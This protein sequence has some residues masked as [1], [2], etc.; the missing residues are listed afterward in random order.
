M[1]LLMSG[2]TLALQMNSKA[3]YHW[4]QYEAL[5]MNSK[6]LYHT[7]TVVRNLVDL[8]AE[9]LQRDRVALRTTHRHLDRHC[10]RRQFERVRPAEME[11]MR[12]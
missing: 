9:S 4:K 7:S 2:W 6:A 1:S 12:Q 3:L 8:I 5:Q 10:P 11:E